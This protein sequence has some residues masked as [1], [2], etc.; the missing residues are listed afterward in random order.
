MVEPTYKADPTDPFGTFHN[1]RRPRFPL[2]NPQLETS[3]AKIK[4]QAS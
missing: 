4:E 1:P 3:Y 2:I